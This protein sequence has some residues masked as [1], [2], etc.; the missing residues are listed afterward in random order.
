MYLP[1]AYVSEAN[2]DASGIIDGATLTSVQSHCDSFLAALT[3]TGTEP[4]MFLLHGDGST[5]SPVTH[6]QV[7][8]SVGTQRRRQALV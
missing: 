1:P 6:L 5:P 4:G 2:V 8:T 3:S 7:R